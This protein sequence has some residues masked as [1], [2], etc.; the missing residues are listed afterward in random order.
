MG[1]APSA[2][3][4][5]P[6]SVVVRFAGD[7]GDGMQLA[8]IQFTFESALEGYDVA[9]F[10][11]FPAEIRAP[12][13][14]LY[15]VSGFQVRFGQ[16]PI[17]TTGD[18][19][20]VLVAMNPAALK[21]NLHLLK[22]DG[23]L[24]VDEDT[25]NNKRNLQLAGYDQ[26]PLDTLE[27]QG[28]RVI[29]L[30]ITRFVR[31]TLKDSGL[32]VR[33]IDRARNIFVLG[34]LLWLFERNLQEAEKLLQQRFKQSAIL[35]ANL[36][37]LRRGYALGE[38][39]EKGIPQL[40]IAV[41]P[42][43]LPPGKYRTLTGISALALGLLLAQE[44]AQ[45][46]LFY[47]SYPITPAS[48]LLHE[49]AQYRRPDVYIIQ[50][51]DEIS[52]ICACIGAAYGGALAVTATS[53]PGFSLMAEALG[54]AVMLELPL[55]VIDLQ[56]AGPSTGM[57]TRSEQ[58]DLL[59]ALFGRHGEAPLVVLAPAT[60]A[61]NFHIIFQACQIALEHTVPVVVLSDLAL[62]FGAQAW[63]IPENL[64][65]YPTI[66]PPLWTN[67]NDAP[68][69]PYLRTEDGAR[70]LAFPGQ[71]NTI[72]VLGGLEKK[73]PE[74]TVSYDPENHER[75]IQ[76]RRQ[77]VLAVQKRLE[78]ATIE[79]GPEDA[80]FL[81]VGWGSTCGVL[82]SVT[83]SLNQ[84]GIPVAHVHLRAL[85]PLPPGFSE[86]IQRAQQVIVVEGNTGQLAGWL[87][88][89]RLPVHHEIHWTRATVIPER[90]LH[91]QIACLLQN[92]DESPS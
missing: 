18:Q 83:R 71:P 81:L 79:T 7:S 31:E 73:A 9:T 33:T 13:G 66:R 55:V 51:E 17:L 90:W 59:Q 75:M 8:G 26:S 72:H 92:P 4:T 3:A 86:L 35:Q 53:G 56:R 89:L 28:Y 22:K 5:S 77:K 23:I 30:P 25:F 85:N 10:P 20:D 87:R 49:L 42:G 80:P 14:T 69:Q 19:I 74:G 70:Y 40:R 36:Q 32:P 45:R 6:S 27:K 52:A 78:P 1:N 63:R 50:T 60:P 58:A 44:R 21:R 67:D 15:G 43:H 37:V 57:P 54:L 46:P 38:T 11:D 76:A 24:I 84:S 41:Q 47:A 16:A 64:N 61:E 62:A 2:E 39:L 88:M 34:F 68:Y 91:Q 82:S 65:T 29:R 48:D 12:R